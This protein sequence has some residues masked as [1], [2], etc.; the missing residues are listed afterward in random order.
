MHDAP[1]R[2]RTA[3][4]GARGRFVIAGGGTGGHVTLALALGEELAALGESV[5]F[6]GTTR[7][8]ETRLVPEAGFELVTLPSRQA[9]GTRA[10][11][12]AA[13]VAA[14][15]PTTLRAGRV[16]HRARAQLVI[17]VG[18]YAAV[19][20]VLAA[21][22]LRVP[23]VVVEPN[24]QP[25]RTNRLAARV[26]A[27]IFVGFEGATTAFGGARRAARVRCLG[28]PL[29]RSMRDAFHAAAPRRALEPPFRLLVF[30]GSQGA[31]QLNEAMI[32]A[33]PALRD[34]ALQVFHQSGAA[35]RDRVAAAYA[36]AGVHA[37]VVAFEPDMPARYRWA[38]L[39]LCRAGAL[40]I[41]ELALAGLP[42]LLV[43]LAHAADDHQSANARQ[44][45]EAGAARM[46]DPRRF[47]AADLVETL[48]G[49]LEKPEQLLAMQR[50]AAQRARPRAAEAIA[51]E[52]R[53]LVMDARV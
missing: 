39:A 45:V 52:C 38:D 1:R 46:F 27:R 15:V 48:L 43:P 4:A 5:L 2:S 6:L 41:A 49:I 16:L 11:A 36:D 23:I 44:L 25:G 24:A 37:E 53:T 33:A 10:L 35:D 31:R 19:P 29:R 13:A 42:A 8:L 40:S 9:V 28:V 14:L 34:S 12:R 26:A 22:P 47:A 30:G 32:E 51:E 17:S 20:A 18:G 50:S 21:V 7:G 3:E